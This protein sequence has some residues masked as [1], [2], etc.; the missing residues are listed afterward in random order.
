MKNHRL[1]SPNEVSWGHSH[2]I[3]FTETKPNGLHD[4]I[5]YLSAYEWD[6]SV[7]D[8][9][10]VDIRENRGFLSCLGKGHAS[11]LMAGGLIG[12]DPD[13]YDTGPAMILPGS[14]ENAKAIWDALRKE[15]WIWS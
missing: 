4:G 9:R 6:R 13:S 5:P 3:V 7:L 14:M 11:V 8:W 15:G 1:Y 2:I 10:Q 12:R